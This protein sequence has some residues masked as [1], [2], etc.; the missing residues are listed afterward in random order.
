MDNLIQACI[1]DGYREIEEFDKL[2]IEYLITGMGNDE[3][4]NKR[5]KLES[6]MDNTLG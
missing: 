3:D 2:I 6:R 1:S 4:L 5:H